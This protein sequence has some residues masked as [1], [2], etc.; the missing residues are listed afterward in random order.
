MKIKNALTAATLTLGLCSSC[1]GPNN[2]YNSIRDWNR[3]LSEQDWVVELVFLGLYILPVYPIAHFGDIVIFN[4]V[5]YWSGDN[6]IND[7]G[8]LDPFVK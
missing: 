4:T 6:P 1:L 8:P 2:A 7:P 3:D 5:N